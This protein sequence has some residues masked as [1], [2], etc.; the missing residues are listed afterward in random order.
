MSW[1][2]YDSVTETL[3]I[4]SDPEM[5]TAFFQGVRDMEEGRTIPLEQLKTE[6]GFDESRPAEI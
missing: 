6:L 4:K 5:M 1:D 2:A 3:E